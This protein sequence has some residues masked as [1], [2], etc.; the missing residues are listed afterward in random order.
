MTLSP[1]YQQTIALAAVF[2]A[3]A[4]V[5]SIAT[6]GQLDEQILATA[7]Y[8]I[9]Q[10]DAPDVLSI[11][12]GRSKV[13]QGLRALECQ[14]GS[15][16]KQRDISITSYAGAL[17][18]LER[19]LNKNPTAIEAL[20]QS[21]IRCKQDCAAEPLTSLQAVKELSSIYK[22]IISPL[23]SHII[24]KGESRYLQLESNASSIRVLLLAALRAI[25]LWRQC[26]G[27]QM[28]L[29]FNRKKYLHAIK[30]LTRIN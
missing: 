11:F 21:I 2:Q 9:Y 6:K 12:G 22:N 17:M 15:L 13:M 25:V 1:I 20:Q 4:E 16:N 7:I 26:G 30:D 8:S 27:G 24:V 23:G 18:G 29:I 10:I 3:L 28:A 14:L 19:R 5:R